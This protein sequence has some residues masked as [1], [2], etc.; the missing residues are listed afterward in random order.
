[1]SYYKCPMVLDVFRL[2]TGDIDLTIKNI[3]DHLQREAGGFNYQRGASYIR[4]AYHGYRKF[5]LLVDQCRGAGDN[6]ALIY[7]AKLVEFVAPLS[8]GRIIQTFDFPKKAITLAQGVVSDL[9]P[10]FFFVEDGKVKLF[11]VHARNSFRAR[12]ED[13]AGLAYYYR[14]E[15]LDTEFYGQPADVEIVDVDKRNDDAQVRVYSLSDLEACLREYPAL[16]TDRFVKAFRTIEDRRLAGEL[17][18]PRAKS[19][20]RD[21]GQQPL[22][23]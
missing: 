3:V 8:A 12:K 5:E 1:M 7:N 13:I 6:A 15:I 18:K 20:K 17:R 14:Q 11:Y 10:N 4:K 9:G 19:E 23:F 2:T 22:P 16:T 21:D